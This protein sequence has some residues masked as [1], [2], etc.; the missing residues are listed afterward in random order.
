MARLAVTARWALL[1]QV[2]TGSAAVLLVAIQF[3]ALA[4]QRPE[5][6]EQMAD[7]VRQHRTAGER[8]GEYEVFVRNLVFYTRFRHE[9]LYD[10]AR[11][12]DFLKS[13]ERILLVVGP[14]DLQR[15]E[16]V[17]GIS[18]K[19]LGEVRYLDTANVRLRTLLNPIPEQ[20]VERV[21]LVT[22]R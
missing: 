13:P 9:P 19:T 5:P 22:N 7:L 6:V 2:M 8:V 20:D 1:P 16:A 4:G 11:A 15:L 14:A 10:E 18:T 21:L 12:L 3:G 17:S